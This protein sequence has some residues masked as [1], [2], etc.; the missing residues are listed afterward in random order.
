MKC[1]ELKRQETDVVTVPSKDIVIVHEPKQKVD[2]TKYLD[3]QTF[4]FD[5]AFDENANND[6]VYRWV[7]TPHL[8]DSR[9]YIILMVVLSAGAS[10]GRGLP[11]QE[12]FAPGLVLSS[13]LQLCPRSEEWLLHMD[14]HP[15]PYSVFNT[16]QR[17]PFIHKFITSICCWFVVHLVVQQINNRSTTNRSNSIWA[18][19]LSTL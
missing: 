7:I 1:A 10:G 15:P 13:I 18:L 12:K 19:V 3:N 14:D 11:P 17:S 16:Q 5:Y 2:L 6:I 4:H 8:L 9:R